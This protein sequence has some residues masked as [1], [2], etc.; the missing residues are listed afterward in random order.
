MPEDP[1]PQA[2]QEFQ[3]AWV[4]EDDDVAWETPEPV[5]PVSR[6]PARRLCRAAP[7]RDAPAGAAAR[8][9]HALGNPRSN[10]RRPAGAPRDRGRRRILAVL[11]L[12]LIGCALWLINAT[13]QPFHDDPTGAVVVTIR[14]A[15]TPARSASCSTSAGVVDNAKLFEADATV[16]LRGRSCAPAST[17]CRRA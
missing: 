14:P 10:G 15:P 13:F 11:A 16:T 17:R 6:E 5:V 1:F 2:T 12:A 9:P 7:R 4:E 8:P 3:P